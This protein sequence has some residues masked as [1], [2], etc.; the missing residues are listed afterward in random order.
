LNVAIVG[1]ESTGKST[2]A[3]GLSERLRLQVLPPLRREILEESGYH[4]F[5][6]WAT[7]TKGWVTLIERQL[8]REE[9]KT[10]IVV[11]DGV[12]QLYCFV[13]RWGWNTISPDRWEALRAR[14]VSR[15]SSYEHVIL[16]PA[17]LLGGP[18]PGRFRSDSQ[19]IQLTRL[20]NASMTELELRGRV[21]AI[22]ALDPL[23]RL[24]EALAFTAGL[25][26]Q[27]T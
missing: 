15:V 24:D 9:T 16:M 3:Q 6:E 11:D 10:D 2:L 7:A 25:R 22:R 26:P 8:E 17:T 12:L 18:A 20:L 13:Q 23:D 4:T 5:F 27:A 21:L 1:G 14:V 19:N